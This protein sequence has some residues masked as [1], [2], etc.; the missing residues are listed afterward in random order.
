MLKFYHFYSA[1]KYPKG[2]AKDSKPNFPN[3]KKNK[4]PIFLEKHFFRRMFSSEKVLQ[5]RKWNFKLAKRNFQ[6]ESFY[7]K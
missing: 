1:K 3:W 4:K 5:R 7:E 6:A 2:Y